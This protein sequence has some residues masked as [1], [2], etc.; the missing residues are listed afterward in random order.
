MVSTRRVGSK[1]LCSILG[2]IPGLSILP[3]AQMGRKLR[4]ERRVAV[5]P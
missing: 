3:G 1:W 2:K 5:P 4:G